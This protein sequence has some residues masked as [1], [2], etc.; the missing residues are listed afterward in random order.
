[1]RVPR[2]CMCDSLSGEPMDTF[3]Q[4]TVVGVAEAETPE[5][6]AAPREEGAVKGHGERVAPSGARVPV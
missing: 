1:M 6:A 5:A 2:R 3:W 4:V